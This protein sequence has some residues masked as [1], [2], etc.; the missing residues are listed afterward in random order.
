M[1]NCLIEK[2]HTHTAQFPMVWHVRIPYLPD[3]CYH[4]T[5]SR[6]M[7]AL[8]CAKPSDRDKEAFINTCICALSRIAE[9]CLATETRLPPLLLIET[10]GGGWAVS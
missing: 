4:G 8:K 9:T 6:V 3:H 1:L 10:F 5:T 2:N 7:L